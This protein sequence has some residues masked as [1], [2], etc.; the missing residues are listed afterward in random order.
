[1]SIFKMTQ[2]G[3]VLNSLIFICIIL[4]PLHGKA[5]DSKAVDVIKT[6]N[7]TLLESMKRADELGFSGRYTLLEPVIKNSFALCF[8]AEKSVGTYWKTL[9]ETQRKLLLYTYTTWSVATYAKRFD[10]YS[11]EKFEVLSETESVHNTVTVIST[12][13]KS[14]E[15]TIDFYYK[16]RE[17]KGKWRIVDVHISGIS[18]LAN[19][20]A[21]FVSVIKDKG[22]DDL[23]SR[24]QNK[25]EFLSEETVHVNDNG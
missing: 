18:Q 24:L 15:E 23:I 7:T 12:L 3:W 14:N 11:G 10:K 8:M 4:K 6:F 21:Q 19:T 17:I 5:E 13:T 9:Q 2:Y 20:R 22:F 16:L 25:I 1:M